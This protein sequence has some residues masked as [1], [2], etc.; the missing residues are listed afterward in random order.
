MTWN[1]TTKLVSVLR[2]HADPRLL[3]D[4]ETERRAVGRI[5]VDQALLRA[6]DRA[7]AP[8]TPPRT[9]SQP[10]APPRDR[11]WVA[12]FTRT[13]STCTRVRAALEALQ[14]SNSS[15]FRQ[16]GPLPRVRQGPTVQRSVGGRGL[17]STSGRPADIGYRLPPVR[18]P[19]L[20]S[21][22]G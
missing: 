12:L 18:R 10:S 19:G 21:G 1:L 22:V 8:P 5:T 15:D 17:P 9:P 6:R 14:K 4:Y 20:T 13:D 2:G 11:R 3:D 7:R 16:H